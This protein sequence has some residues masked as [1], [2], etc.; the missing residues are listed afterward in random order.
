MGN[1]L[2]K[3]KYENLYLSPSWMVQAAMDLSGSC[4]SFQ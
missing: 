1:K 4:I 2:Y 3:V